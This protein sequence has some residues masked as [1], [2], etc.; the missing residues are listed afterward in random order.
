MHHW[1]LFCHNTFQM[2]SKYSKW[3]EENMHIAINKMAKESLK[4]HRGAYRDL[5]QTNQ[6][7]LIKYLMTSTAA[8]TEYQ[9]K[10]GKGL[11]KE[12]DCTL[13]QEWFFLQACNST[14]SLYF[15]WISSSHKH[16]IKLYILQFISQKH[17][18]QYFSHS[19]HLHPHSEKLL[20]VL[21]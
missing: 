8:M 18:A 5:R 3:S 2:Q 1:D 20:G 17:K 10:R 9:K 19:K 7:H 11:W 16:F 21:P 13:S 15:L 4:W 14:S 12:R 6:K